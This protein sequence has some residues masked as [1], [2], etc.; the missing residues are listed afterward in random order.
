MVVGGWWLVCGGHV[1]KIIYVTVCLL[2][3]ENTFNAFVERIALKKSTLDQ[4]ALD[5]AEANSIRSLVALSHHFV[6]HLPDDTLFSV[7][8]F[9]WFGPLIRPISQML[10]KQSRGK[11]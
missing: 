8:L 1:P 4:T 6:H 11:R 3:C 7:H 2:I 10:N 5:P 9:C